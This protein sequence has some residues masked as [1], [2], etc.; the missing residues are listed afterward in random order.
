MPTQTTYIDANGEKKTG[1]II[2]GTTYTDEGGTTPVGV[3]SIVNAGGRLYLESLTPSVRILDSTSEIKIRHGKYSEEQTKVKSEQ[4]L[5]L[6]ALTPVEGDVYGRLYT[7]KKAFFAACSGVCSGFHS[8]FPH[9]SV[10]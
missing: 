5:D 9:R 3:G 8:C 1:Y 7:L 6:S 10:G 2:D 4:S